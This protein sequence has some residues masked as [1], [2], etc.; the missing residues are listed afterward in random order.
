MKMYI[1]GC[2]GLLLSKVQKLGKMEKNRGGRRQHM[3]ERYETD[4]E[5]GPYGCTMVLLCTTEISD[6][7]NDYELKQDTNNKD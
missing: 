2:T 5:S 7:C 3:E 1:N 6:S 4:Y